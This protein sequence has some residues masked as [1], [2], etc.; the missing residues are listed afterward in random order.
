[1]SFTPISSDPIADT[2]GLQN[3]AVSKSSSSAFDSVLSGVSAAAYYSGDTINAFTETY[4]S[5]TLASISALTSNAVYN[6]AGTAATLATSTTDAR[7]STYLTGGYSTAT[8][9]SLSSPSAYLTGDTSIDS[10][11]AM[12]DQTP[13]DMSQMIAL[14][15]KISQDTTFFGAETNIIKAQNDATKA[16]IAN[17]K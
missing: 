13:A 14:Q 9:S 12:A 1:M 8:S 11:S 5:D 15:L 4:G 7:T 3:V 6:S 10:L 2:Q 16:A 17:M